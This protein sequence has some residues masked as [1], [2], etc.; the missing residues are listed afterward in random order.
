MKI[1]Q[2]WLEHVE[3]M[4]ENSVPKQA[5]VIGA[6]D[7]NVL[8]DNAASEIHRSRNRPSA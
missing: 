6:K 7:E 4:E 8:A 2:D 1:R 3:R 5:F